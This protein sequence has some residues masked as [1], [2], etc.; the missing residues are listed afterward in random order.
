MRIAFTLVLIMFLT[1]SVMSQAKKEKKFKYSALPVVFFSPE[2]GLAFGGLINTNFYIQDSSYRPS[3]MLLGGA[4]TL[5]KQLLVYLPFEFNWGGNKYLAKGEIGYYRYFYNYYGIGT[6]V[7]SDFEV[8][9]VN[10]P[11]L[12]IIGAYRFYGD[13]YAGI[14]YNFDD[15]NIQSLDSEG[16]LLNDQISGYQGSL[17][18]LAGLVHTYDSRDYNFS[19]TKGWFITTTLE[20]NGSVLG[21]DFQFSRITSD[22]IK[23]I[24]VAENHILA[25]NLYGGTTFG[26]PP[27]QELLLYGGGNKA[28]GYYLG[29]YRDKALIVFQPEYRFPIWRRFSGVAFGTL[30]NVAPALNKFEISKT[31]WNAG[32]GLRYMINPDDRLNLRVDYAIGK[33]TSGLYIT[34]GEAF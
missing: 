27:F 17:V 11:R 30:G 3:T 20:Y 14:K 33:E 15:Y 24:S 6:D 31:K 9:T 16:S 13:H 23:Y 1:G 12:R 21:S 8:Y 29:H 10:F 2:T 22:I 32:L 7:D 5:K 26:T 18:S 25:L 34:F 4:Y 19:A 28:R